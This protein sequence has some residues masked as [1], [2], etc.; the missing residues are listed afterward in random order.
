MKTTRQSLFRKLGG[1]AIVRG[2]VDDFYERVLADPLLAPFFADVDTELL[3][4]HQTAFLSVVLGA[5]SDA[6]EGRSMREAHADLDLEDVHF[7]RVA[8]HLQDALVTGG[9][10]GPDVETILANVGSLR[11]E[12]LNR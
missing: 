4:A 10:E 11:K 2:V 12:I 3:Q 7:D 5:L 1:G 9:I 6:Y 8:A